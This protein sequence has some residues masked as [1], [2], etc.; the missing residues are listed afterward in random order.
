M[1]PL[2]RGGEEVHRRRPDETRD[3]QVHRL[4]VQFTR[5]GALLQ[6]PSFQHRDPVPQ[7][8]GL[9]LVV[10]DVDG[11]DAQPALQPGDLRS[12]LATQLGVEV[13][14]RLVEE[15]RVGLSDD[16]TS[17]GNALP[18]TARQVGGFA[19]QVFRQFQHPGRLIHPAANLLF[20]ELVA[21]EAQRECDVLPDRQ[22]RVQG[23][24]LEDHGQ[25]AVLGGQVV[26]GFPVDQ[27]IPGCD[28]LQSDDHAQGR[29][30]AAAGRAD[31]NHELAVS[32]VQVDV[33]DGL[34][35]VSVLLDEVLEGDLGH[36]F[37]LL[38]GVSP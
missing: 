31:E 4:L 25:V 29:R 23:V 7:R 1:I 36:N 19:F 16:R 9:G 11:G 32:D 8:H 20:R 33:V 5:G 6:H 35:T 3:E 12:H 38:V 14:Q 10:G 2:N 30:L 28:V 13:A 37:L 24:V 17:H 15:E 18:L 21:V 22:V 34:E 26:H 27:E